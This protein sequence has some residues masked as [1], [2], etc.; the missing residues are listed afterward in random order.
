[1]TSE[2]C[3]CNGAFRHASA[4]TPPTSVTFKNL[5]R[6]FLALPLRF[7]P[8]QRPL[9][10]FSPSSFSVLPSPSPPVLSTPSSPVRVMGLFGRKT[11]PPPPPPVQH[12]PPPPSMQEVIF[13]MRFTSKTIGRQA[14]KSQKQTT[15]EEKKAKDAMAKNNM[16]GARIHAENAIR[17]QSESLSYLKL[18]S[19]L[20]AVAGK[21]QAQQVRAQVSDSMVAVTANLD[22]ALATMDVSQIS[23]TMEKFIQQSEDLDLSTKVMDSAIGESTSSSTPQNQVNGLLQRIADENN[24]DVGDRISGHAAPVGQ[25]THVAN[26]SAVGA[27]D[28]LE[29]RL[30]AL[31]GGSAPRY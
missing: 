8:L 9:S 13:K 4:F 2:T 27:P 7:S 11:A 17:N 26:S 15:M 29:A 18:Q 31:Q 25:P 19:Q 12:A 16:A 28:D 14:A 30:A 3:A 21:L 24:L 23:Y 20:E 1:M 10:S 22:Q 6:R 5:Y